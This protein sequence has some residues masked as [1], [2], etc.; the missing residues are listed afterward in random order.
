VNAH[1]AS[2]HRLLASITAVLGAALAW[3]FTRAFPG[4]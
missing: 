4:A 1:A 2:P 3:S